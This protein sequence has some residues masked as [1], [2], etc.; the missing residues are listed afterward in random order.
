MVTYTVVFF[1]RLLPRKASRITIFRTKI[2]SAFATG[3]HILIELKNSALIYRAGRIATLNL[4][5][6][7]KA[8]CFNIMV[9]YIHMA[10]TLQKW[11][12]N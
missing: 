1:G 4:P 2:K 8:S 5:T 11:R 9:P 10:A 7:T 12:M 3:L 6:G